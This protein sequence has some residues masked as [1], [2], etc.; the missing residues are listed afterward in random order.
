MNMHTNTNQQ[1]VSIKY[2]Y[3][4]NWKIDR[5]MDG[6]M[7]GWIDGS[8]D[9]SIDWL[10]DWTNCLFYLQ[11]RWELTKVEAIKTIREQATIASTG[12]IMWVWMNYHVSTKFAP[13]DFRTSRSFVPVRVGLVSFIKLPHLLASLNEGASNSQVQSLSFSSQHDHDDH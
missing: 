3:K 6:W 4:Y 12:I 1:R 8:M 11:E 7:D 2:T 13:G 5:L 9:R 10:I